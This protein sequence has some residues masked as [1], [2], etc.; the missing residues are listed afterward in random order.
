LGGLAQKATILTEYNVNE[1]NTNTFVVDA[2]DL[3]FSKNILEPGVSREIALVNANIILESFNK[4]G[5]TVFSPGSK[6]FAAGK[7]Y[8]KSTY[9]KAQFPFVSSNIYDSETNSLLFEPY[10]IENRNGKRVAFIGLTSIFQ[11]EGIQVKN[12]EAALNSILKEVIPKSDIRILLFSSNDNDMKNIRKKYNNDI[13]L[14][15]RSHYKGRSFDGGTDTPT[16]GVGEKGKLLYKFDLDVQ[17]ASM[18]FTDIA[19]CNRTIEDKTRRLDTMKKG[20]MLVDLKVLFKDNAQQLNKIIKFE[21][22]IEEANQKIENAVNRI[23]FEKIELS[24]K[25]SG[26]IDILKIVDEGKL[27]IQEITRLNPDF[28]IKK[29]THAHDHD[30]DGYPD[31]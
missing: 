16:Y 15:I 6:D 25:V 10:I 7:D 21:N 24:K 17:D 29:K 4:M 5:C 18:P 20:N 8:I 19:W 27:Q 1:L 14:I 23:T 2:G 11:S 26:R 31:H 9:Q 3:F 22:Q 13:A 12:P 30:G 28:E